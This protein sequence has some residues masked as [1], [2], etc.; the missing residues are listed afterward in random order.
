[1]TS[2]PKPQKRVKAR[3]PMRRTRI[4]R[5]P[6]RRL[7][8]AGADPAYLDFVRSLPCFFNGATISVCEGRVHAHHAGRRP[9]ISMKAADDTAIPLCEKHHRA[10][11]DHR[12]PFAGL[13]KF[14]KF[15]WSMRVVADTQG[16]YSERSH[17]R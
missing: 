3:K 4:K 16:R 8:R 7:K 14:E 15:A 2:F 11:H 6:P 17:E 9:G 1:M 12:P 5:R 13:T 10:F